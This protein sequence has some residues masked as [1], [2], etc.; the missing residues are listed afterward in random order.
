[1]KLYTRSYLLS[2]ALEVTEHE[3]QSTLL[4]VERIDDYQEIIANSCGR[5]LRPK[6][7]T[8]VLLLL[9]HS[10]AFFWLGEEEVD[11]SLKTERIVASGDASQILEIICSNETMSRLRKPE[12]APLVHI[13][14]NKIHTLAR[15]IANICRVAQRWVPCCKPA[16]SFLRLWS[17]DVQKTMDANYINADNS[18]F[19]ISFSQIVLA[20]AEWWNLPITHQKRNAQHT[21]FGS[22]KCRSGESR[23]IS[24]WF[25]LLN[26]VMPRMTC[27]E[28]RSDKH[29]GVR[30]IC[31]RVEGRTLTYTFGPV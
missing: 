5:L 7:Q 25:S 24:T 20:P 27:R 8:K 12:L 2:I 17:A 23:M 30:V 6:A 16:S 18:H 29:D 19:M 9:E 11:F 3:A 21:T 4:S 22:F 31:S 14:P 1:M 15:R 13:T 26:S 28:I 10:S